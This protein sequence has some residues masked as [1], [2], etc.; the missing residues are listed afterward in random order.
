M[1][2][3]LLLTSL[4]SILAI[5]GCTNNEPLDPNYQHE[6]AVGIFLRSTDSLSMLYS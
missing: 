3:V 2:Y 4:L 1:K 6:K 5:T